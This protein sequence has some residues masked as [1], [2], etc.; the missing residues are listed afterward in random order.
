MIRCEGVRFDYP[1]GTRALDALDLEI[2]AG[3]R[4]AITGR[5]GSGKS[6]L[7]RLWNGLLQPTEGRVLIDGRSTEGRRVADLAR[8]IGL[9]FQDPDTQ[10]FR[11]TCR[12]EVEFGPRNLGLAGAALDEAVTQALD[13]VGLGDASG[14]NPFDL[15][16]AARKRLALASVLAMGTPVVVIDEPTPGQDERGLAI[17]H[18]IVERLA[19]DGRTVVAISHDARFISETFE[20]VVTLEAGRVVADGP[21]S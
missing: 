8:T 15:G 1:D 3:E 16:R 10:L 19:S 11:A 7:V 6:T 5:N 17:L 18:D 9:V 14:T 4:V 2:A 21:P 20:R 13:A 12:A